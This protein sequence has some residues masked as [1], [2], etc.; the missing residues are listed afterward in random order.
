M[1]LLF[2]RNRGFFYFAALMLSSLPIATSTATV[3]I[4]NAVKQT[5]NAVIINIQQFAQAKNILNT[6]SNQIKYVNNNNELN[7]SGIN[8]L[9]INFTNNGVVVK[10]NTSFTPYISSGTYNGT[11]LPVIISK[12]AATDYSIYGPAGYLNLQQVATNLS[13]INNPGF[14]P[15]STPISCSSGGTGNNVSYI[16]TPPTTLASSINPLFSQNVSGSSALSACGGF[17]M[18]LL[19]VTSSGSQAT[20]S[21]RINTYVCNQLNS[22][23]SACAANSNISASNTIVNVTR[24]CPTING[25]QLIVDST[26]SGNNF[27]A[28][29]CSCPSGGEI[30]ADGSC[31]YCSIHCQA[32]SSPTNCTT[33]ANGYYI[34]NPGSGNICVSACPSGTYVSGSSC[35]NCTTNCSS[36]T[37]GNN[38]SACSS[39]YLYNN[40]TCVPSCPSGTYVSGSSCS[41][42]STNCT[43]CTSGVHCS[44]CSSGNY[45]YN[46]ACVSSCPS[47]T[48][49]AGS[50]CVKCPYACNVCSAN[51]S[52]SS[53]T[54]GG[55]LYNNNGTTVCTTCPANSSIYGTGDFTESWQL[56]DGFDMDNC[57]CNSNAPIWNNGACTA[58]CP[59]GTYNNNGSC[60]NCS[61]NCSSCTA[62]NNC[63]ACSSGYLYNHA[64]VSSCPSGTYANGNSCSSCP[65]NCST[66]TSSSSCSACSNGY[67][68]TTCTICN[69]YVSGS[70]CNSCP[71]GCSSCT[72]SACTSCS[73][74]S[75]YPSGNQCLQCPG[76]SITNGDTSFGQIY[77]GLCG[78]NGCNA[79]QPGTNC[80]NAPAGCNQYQGTTVGSKCFCS[81]STGIGGYLYWYYNGSGYSCS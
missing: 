22:S 71:T 16:N 30:A 67:S 57:S 68:G 59:S 31:T 40:S 64:C 5:S 39:G 63:S 8:R 55:W 47:T 48:Y 69:G 18:E 13:Y 45:L 79:S 1:K 56:T 58:S 70:T 6:V 24:T 73:S 21:F 28:L 15:S 2:K 36:C 34:Y 53:C 25:T 54:S 43:S 75:Y 76:G 17:L 49:V 65:N 50:S 3:R 51:G 60:S 26:S 19:N 10:S 52:C 12:S 23:T 11:F 33:C 80:G 66:C 32:C 72:G 38:C 78:S 62:G 20:Y 7:N 29:N 46:S 42:C 35:S 27:Y 61:T 4:V 14:T 77:W 81:G 74:N 41:N 44:A 9:G 37:A